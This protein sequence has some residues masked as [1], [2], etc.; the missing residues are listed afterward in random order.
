MVAVPLHERTEAEGL[1]YLPPKLARPEETGVV[2]VHRD[3][4]GTL[5]RTGLAPTDYAVVDDTGAVLYGRADGDW[6]CGTAPASG[7]PRQCAKPWATFLS[8]RGREQILIQTGPDPYAQVG[9]GTAPP[10]TTSPQE[11]ARYLALDL[12]T[13][14]HE[15]VSVPRFDGDGSDGDIAHS[16]GVVIPAAGLPPGVRDRL[17]F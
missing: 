3:G 1:S 4:A 2:S 8:W 12:R 14:H 10:Q 5:V 6:T 11:D 15:A 17:A 16:A 9:I 7:V 13:G